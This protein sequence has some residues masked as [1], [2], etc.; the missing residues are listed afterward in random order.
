M[1]NLERKKYPEKILDKT[2]YKGRIGGEGGT[3]T[4]T[5]LVNKYQ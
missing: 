5:P 2:K 1:K 3:K 4:K